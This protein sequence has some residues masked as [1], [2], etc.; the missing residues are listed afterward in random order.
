MRITDK[1][2]Q[3]IAYLADQLEDSNSFKIDLDHFIKLAEKM[4][5][6]LYY[7][8][9]DDLEIVEKLDL[10]PEFDLFAP[11][12]GLLQRLLSKSNRE[13]V[14]KYQHRKK[15]MNQV[16]KTAKIYYSVHLLIREEL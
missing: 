7:R 5:E 10:L 11:E 3:D 12:P 4:R 9:D 8:Y 2:F 1:H 15:I 14:G 6:E 13:M 16:R